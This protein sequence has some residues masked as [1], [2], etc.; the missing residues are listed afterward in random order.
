M[1]AVVFLAVAPKTQAFA[2]WTSHAQWIL[3]KYNNN[4][5]INLL[6]YTIGCGCDDGATPADNIRDA[7]AGRASNRS[8]YGTAPGGYTYLQHNL[9]ESMYHIRASS[10]QYS[11]TYRVTSIAGGSHSSGSY[12]YTGAAFDVD[13]INGQAVSSSN[14]YYRGFMDA[15]RINGAIEV[16]GPG[17]TGHSTHIHCAWPNT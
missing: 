14:P 16:L 5:G 7:A 6:E 11:F 3:S 17:N 15:C 2:S 8:N 13:R 1:L 10:G 4:D 12:H 9:L